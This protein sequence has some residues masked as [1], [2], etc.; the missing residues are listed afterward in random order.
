MG[1]AV[2]KNTSQNDELS[3]NLRK[4]K[5]YFNN[6]YEEE[7]VEAANLAIAV[8]KDDYSTNVELNL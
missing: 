1:G 6:N 3:I 2:K 8:Q 7:A 4:E 5:S